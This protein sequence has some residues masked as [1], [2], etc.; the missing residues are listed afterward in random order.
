MT[1][2]YYLVIL[3]IIGVF[4]PLLSI[5]LLLISLYNSN[6]V[7]ARQEIKRFNFFFSFTIAYIAFGYFRT[8]ETGDLADYINSYNYIGEKILY[9]EV[10]DL[11]KNP[12]TYFY[13]SWY[14]SLIISKILNLPFALYQGISMFFIYFIALNQFLYFSDTYSKKDYLIFVFKVFT[15]FS[16]IDLISSFRTTLAVALTSSFIF[17]KRKLGLIGIG[18][19][20]IT[21]FPVI[22]RSIKNIRFKHLIPVITVLFFF[23]TFI[24]NFLN[25]KI[26]TYFF[27]KWSSFN[28]DDSSEVYIFIYSIF[29]IVLIIITLLRLVNNTVTKF[30]FS[31]VLL[32]VPFLFFRTIFIRLY[33]SSFILFTPLLILLLNKRNKKLEDWILLTLW[34]FLIDIRAFYI[35]NSS[36]K[37]FELEFPL[38][39][40][41]G[42]IFQ[43]L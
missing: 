32:S 39:L 21:L 16:A 24:M 13:P 18:I 22:I 40:L 30:I 31:Y 28:F 10:F 19:H 36:Y 3:V 37:V 43:I 35:I 6:S 42:P 20:P 41:L 11:F 33:I 4:S 1:K 8:N 17:K 9:G 29:F 7:I 5:L 15:I 2:T 34:V 12:Y 38:N 27:G 25:S 26:N 14:F 23:G